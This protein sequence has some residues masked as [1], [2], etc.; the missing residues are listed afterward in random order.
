MNKRVVAEVAVDA[1]SRGGAKV[2]KEEETAKPKATRTFSEIP[3]SFDDRIVV[4][5]L[6][7]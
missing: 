2:K 4:A 5:A 3:S 1:S 6:L 7:L